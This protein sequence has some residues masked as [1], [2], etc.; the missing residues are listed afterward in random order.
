MPP[1]TRRAPRDA[2]CVVSMVAVVTDR[3]KGFAIAGLAI[4]GIACLL[5]MGMFMFVVSMSH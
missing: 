5:L 1:R 3:P 2:V 4:S